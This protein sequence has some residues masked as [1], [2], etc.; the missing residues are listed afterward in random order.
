MIIPSGVILESSEVFTIFTSNL[1]ISLLL[2]VISHAPISTVEFSLTL[3]AES[4][5]NFSPTG[6]SGSSDYLPIWFS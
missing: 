2:I 6:K 3:L 5:L 1:K 4:K